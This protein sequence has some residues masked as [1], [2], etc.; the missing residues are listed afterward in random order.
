[1]L[2]NPSTT[3]SIPQQAIDLSGGSLESQNTQAT[4]SLAELTLSAQ[5]L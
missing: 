1:M 4:S 2:I 5:V 3:I